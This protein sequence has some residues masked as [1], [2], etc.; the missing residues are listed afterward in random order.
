MERELTWVWEVSAWEFAFVTVILGGGA[1][2]LTGRAMANTWQPGW[3]LAC[4]LALLT[5]AVRFIHFA[6]FSGTLISPWYY[7]VDLVVLLAFGF[8]GMRHTRA[9][10]MARQYSFLFARAGPLG[11]T[12]RPG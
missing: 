6:L 12:R 4:Y 3:L 7:C 10:Q 11:W 9:G 5:G 8:A 1:A 2:W